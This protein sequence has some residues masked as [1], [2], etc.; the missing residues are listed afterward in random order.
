MAADAV[1]G[2]LTN[3]I[4]DAVLDFIAIEVCDFVN[5]EGGD[6]SVCQGGVKIMTPFFMAAIAEG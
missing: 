2:F 3:S 4:T 6:R 1:D 5:V